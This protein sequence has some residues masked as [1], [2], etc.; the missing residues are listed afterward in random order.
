M[1]HH[2]PFYSQSFFIEFLVS[3]VHTDEPPPILFGPILIG[4]AGSWLLTCGSPL[5]APTLLSSHQTPTLFLSPEQKLQN[6][7]GKTSDT[8]AM[9]QHSELRP[10]PLA[11]HPRIW[12]RTPSYGTIYPPRST[13]PARA[14]VF[15]LG[16][17]CANTRALSVAIFIHHSPWFPEQDARAASTPTTFVQNVA[18]SSGAA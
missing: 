13:Q 9:S 5:N 3:T 17:V 6:I 1:P 12:T 8:Q 10:V 4:S 14:K 11:C 7:N 16:W 2:C 15:N 18:P